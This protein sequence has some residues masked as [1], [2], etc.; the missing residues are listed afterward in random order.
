MCLLFV[1]ESNVGAGCGAHVCPNCGRVYGHRKSLRSH[2]RNACGVAPQFQCPDCPYRAK[3]NHSLRRHWRRMHRARVVV[4]DASA[5]A[6][7]AGQCSILRQ[8]LTMDN[9][10]ADSLAN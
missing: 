1:A 4:W 5:A 6:D 2:M 9:D 7:G 8:R 3:Y 10:V